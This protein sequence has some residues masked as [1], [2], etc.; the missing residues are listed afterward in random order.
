MRNEMN[1][2]W[3]E[4]NSNFHEAKPKAKIQA[5]VIRSSFDHHAD[6]W[7]T[8]FS[9]QAGTLVFYKGYDPS[10]RNHP[11]T[12]ESLTKNQTNITDSLFTFHQT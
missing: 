6:Q 8:E 1:S 12:C 11:N 7:T 9:A 2:M 3:K 5:Y 10:P 4:A